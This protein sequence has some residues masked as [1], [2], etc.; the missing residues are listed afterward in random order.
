MLVLRSW[1][2]NTSI[3]KGHAYKLVIFQMIK[4]YPHFMKL[5]DSALCLKQTFAEPV[6][7]IPYIC[8]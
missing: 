2:Q 7:P 5:E 3:R 8:I 4:R 6:E 1:K